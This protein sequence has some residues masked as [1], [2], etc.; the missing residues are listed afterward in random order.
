MAR[1]V[2]VGYDGSQTS[3]R[4]IARAAEEAG[5]GGRVVVVTAIP[6]ANAP[7]LAGHSPTLPEEPGRLLEEAAALLDGQGV[8]VSTETGEGDPVDALVGA[9]RKAHAELIVVGARGEDYVARA[10]RGSVGERLVSRAPCDL[11]VAR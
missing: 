3:R 4:A 1:S 8:D 2:V 6:P 11:L 5:T 7:A 10:L 9:A